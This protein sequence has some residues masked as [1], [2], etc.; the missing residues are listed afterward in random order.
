MQSSSQNPE[1]LRIGLTAEMETKS[2]SSVRKRLHI[3]K[4]FS[5]NTKHLN[6]VKP[7]AVDKMSV[8]ATYILVR[9][10]ALPQSN[11][12]EQLDFFGGLV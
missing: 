1:T 6:S 2:K 11:V 12:Y 7:S 9:G 4:D 10:L 5:S 8:V 3:R